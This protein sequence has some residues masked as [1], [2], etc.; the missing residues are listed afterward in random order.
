MSQITSF[1]S[2]NLLEKRGEGK[3]K[4]QIPHYRNTSSQTQFPTN[5][6][7][8]C[9]HKTFLS[10]M[11]QTLNNQKNHLTLHFDMSNKQLIW[12]LVE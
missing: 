10:I 4:Q 1:I 3:T 9:K 8:I 6:K 12:P 5:K 7:T 11:L 2:K